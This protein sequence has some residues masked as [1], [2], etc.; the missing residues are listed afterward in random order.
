M[1]MTFTSKIACGLWCKKLWRCAARWY[2]FQ[3]P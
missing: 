3:A 1:P 2:D